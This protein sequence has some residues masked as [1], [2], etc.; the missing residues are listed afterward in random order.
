MPEYL[1]YSLLDYWNKGKVETVLL[2]SAE[3]SKLNFI[4][5][6]GEG[7]KMSPEKTVYITPPG[8][9]FPAHLT[10]LQYLSKTLNRRE[11]LRKQ[12]DLTELWEILA[13][14]PQ[15]GRELDELSQLYFSADRPDDAQLGKSALFLELQGDRV[16]FIRKQEKFFPRN[17]EMVEKLLRDEK[18]R[19]EREKADSILVE[20]LKAFREGKIEKLELKAETV[21]ALKKLAV[22]E[23][24]NGG[25][26]HTGIGALLKQAG[27]SSAAAPF[28]LLVKMGIWQADENLELIKFDVPIRFSARVENEARILADG[29]SDSDYRQQRE[30]LSGLFTVTI[31]APGTLE[32]DDGFSWEESSDGFILWVHLANPSAFISR[33]SLLEREAQKRT[34]SL[35]LPDRRIPMLPPLL[36]EERF[37]LRENQERAALTLRAELDRDYRIRDYRFIPSLIKVKKRLSYEKVDEL[38][39]TEAGETPEFAFLSNLLQAALSFK[40]SRMENG[41]FELNFPRVDIRLDENHNLILEKDLS[42]T[43]AQILVSE[44]N[45]LAN[46]LAAEY[47]REQNL[48][49]FYRTQEEPEKPLPAMPVFNPLTWQEILGLLPR[50]C[51][52]TKADRHFSLG[53]P[54]YTQ[55]SSPLRRY[56]DFLMQR[57][58]LGWLQNREIEY[59]EAELAAILSQIK[60]GMEL[61]ANLERNSREYWMYKYLENQKGLEVT[62]VVLK[63]LPSQK[64]L[65]LFEDLML[66]TVVKLP[67]G[68]NYPPGEKLHFKLQGVNPRRVEILPGF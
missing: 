62:S 30:N 19:L 37:S 44:L 59:S 45:I 11:E 1:P 40:T 25:G 61:L 16:Y 43:P 34:G 56:P 64:V 46:R 52:G 14:N 27:Y 23:E 50:T 4:S 53:C 41:G 9:G 33:E 21:E 22:G 55:I 57:Q 66:K 24:G 63:I 15:E 2:L 35:Y 68:K 20:Q 26:G 28:H 49:A 7:G 67:P 58:L 10:P 3:N 8:G 13:D 51:W 6:Q 29:L 42:D 60:E 38:L 65:I 5:P 48:P 36:G 47:M 39:S 12:I 18:I 17:R 54:V 31:D 32:V